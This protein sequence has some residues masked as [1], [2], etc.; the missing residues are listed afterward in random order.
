L[1]EFIENTTHDLATP[2]TVLQ[3]NLSTIAKEHS[4]EAVRQAM[5]EAQYIGALLGNL[6][7]SAKF[8]AAA[9]LRAADSGSRSIATQPRHITSFADIGHTLSTCAQVER[10]VMINHLLRARG[11]GTKAERTRAT[12]LEAAELVFA[13]KGY[14]AARLEDVA[15]RVGIRRASLVYYFRDKRALYE[16]VLAG[17]LGELLERYRAVVN[18][19]V[20]L[21]ERLEGL[22]RAWI[23]FIGERPSLAR[24]LLW[25]VAEASATSLAARFIEPV[26]ATLSATI[27]EGQRYGVFRSIEPTHVIFALTGA[28]IFFVTAAPA[29]SPGVPSGART[30]AE[31]TAFGDEIL[32]FARR[33]L[34]RD[35][36]KQGTE[37]AGGA[38]PQPRRRTRACG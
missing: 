11:A 26:V 10:R 6:A 21:T 29:L 33:L 22:V 30:H 12:V 38:P 31:L 37:Q 16:A 8:E 14:A 19:R 2:L 28:T 35:P 4:P 24:L 23:S 13:E 18:D 25:E 15:L 17:V 32:G 36:A 1:L 7:I 20:P 5:N 3:G 27:V 9:A 34:E